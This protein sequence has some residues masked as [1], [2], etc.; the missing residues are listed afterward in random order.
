MVW[1]NSTFS[2]TDDL[3]AQVW[4]YEL[5]DIKLTLKK[6]HNTRNHWFLYCPKL[7][8]NALDLETADLEKAK[9]TAIEA[10]YHEL[11]AKINHYID[12]VTTLEQSSTGTVYKNYKV[13]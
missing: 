9:K 11:K 3:Q 2:K 10:F 6:L 4:E 5:S 1:K 8:D 13:A 12:I 7:N